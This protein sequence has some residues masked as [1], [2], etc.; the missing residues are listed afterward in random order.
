MANRSIRDQMQT[1]G[2]PGLMRRPV[3]PPQGPQV[4]TFTQPAAPMPRPQPVLAP[5]PVTRAAPGTFGP[6]TGAAVL[7]RPEVA[8]PKPMMSVPRSP[9]PMPGAT[10]PGTAAP[11][12]PSPPM[13]GGGDV[14]HLELRR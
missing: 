5:T 8:T 11:G 10:G 4:G 14:P 7:A 9:A 1:G 3:M 12:T 2:P 6:T 13:S